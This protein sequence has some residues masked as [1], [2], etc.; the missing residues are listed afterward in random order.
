[1]SLQSLDLLPAVTL[2]AMIALVVWN[3]IH[4]TRIVARLHEEPLPRR[5]R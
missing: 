4:S 2:L 3:G 5:E 1:M